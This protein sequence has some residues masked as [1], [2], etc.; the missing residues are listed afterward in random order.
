MG[1]V[2]AAVLRRPTVRHRELGARLRQ[3]REDPGLTQK[4][5]AEHPRRERGAVR[6]RLAGARAGLVD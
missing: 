1:G 4:Q 2:L 6:A 5:V 3:L